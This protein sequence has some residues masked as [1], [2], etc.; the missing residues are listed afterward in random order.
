MIPKGLFIND[1]TQTQ[2]G[3]RGCSHFCDTLYKGLGKICNLVRQRGR[4][5]ENLQICVTS[6]MDDPLF[7]WCEKENYL[8]YFVVVQHR[9]GKK[10][11]FLISCHPLMTSHKF[12]F[13]LVPLPLSNKFAFFTKASIHS[14]TKV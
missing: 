9:P 14:V 6:L 10:T 2:V 13:F 12:I 4:G 11:F 7:V 8:F 5:S 1:V 3:G